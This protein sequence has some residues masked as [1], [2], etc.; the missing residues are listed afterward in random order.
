[1]RGTT[2]R[3]DGEGREVGA[4]P[5]DGCRWIC[6]G[7]AYKCLQ[8]RLTHHTSNIGWF[9]NKLRRCYVRVKKQTHTLLVF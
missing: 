1:M 7:S 8:Q 2:D 9:I 3:V 4:E 5:G 6:L